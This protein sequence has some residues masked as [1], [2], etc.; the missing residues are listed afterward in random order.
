MNAE[1]KRILDEARREEL[2]RA[3]QLLNAALD[4][5]DGGMR[6]DDFM[7]AVCRYGHAALSRRVLLHDINLDN[8]N[9]NNLN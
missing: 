3:Q 8:A 7:G 2:L 6:E 1:Q 5:Y 9:R 4:F